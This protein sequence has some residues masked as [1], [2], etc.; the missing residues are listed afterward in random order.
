MA[1]WQEHVWKLISAV[2]LNVFG[3]QVQG[4]VVIMTGCSPKFTAVVAV[5]LL[6][7]WRAKMVIWNG[8]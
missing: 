3:W 8:P 4:K 2:G 1:Q 7:L 5:A 6:S